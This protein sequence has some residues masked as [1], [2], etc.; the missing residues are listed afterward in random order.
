M[1]TAMRIGPFRFFF[2]SNENDEP[3]HIHVRAAE[4][5]AKYWLEPL[6]LS[7]N[8]GFN[9]R[10]LKQIERHLQDNLAYLIEAWDEFFG[11]ADDD[12]TE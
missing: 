1:P 9:T 4:N 10:Q 11:V 12:E 8:H 7:W 5:E 6:E 2:Y 3:H